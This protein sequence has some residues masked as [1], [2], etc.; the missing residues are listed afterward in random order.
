MAAEG[1]NY[2]EILAFYYEGTQLSRIDGS[3]IEEVKGMASKDMTNTR[4][5]ELFYQAYH[6]GWGYIWALMDS[7]GQRQSRRLQRTRWL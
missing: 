2:R 3:T 7:C 1:K 6:E 4:L 5:I